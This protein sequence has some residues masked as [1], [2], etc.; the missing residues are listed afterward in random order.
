MTKTS[1]PTPKPRRHA[2]MLI[3]HVYEPDEAAQLRVLAK[4]LEGR[5]PQLKA[6]VQE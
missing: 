5:F 4:L 3:E 2:P 1:Q 6:T